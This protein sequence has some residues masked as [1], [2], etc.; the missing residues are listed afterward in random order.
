MTF[1]AGFNCSNGIVLCT[2]SLESDGI[3]KRSVNKIRM[4]GTAEWGIA[5]AGAGAPGIIEKF[6]DEVFARIGRGIYNRKKIEAV[7]EEVLSEFRSQYREDDDVFRVL[8]G[9][10]CAGALDYRLYRS[11]A[12]HLSPMKDHAHIGMGHSLWKFVSES[13]YAKGNSVEDN[14][15][16]G[17]FIMKLAIEHVGGVEGPIQ[18]VSYT[19]GDDAWRF[20]RPGTVWRL[21]ADFHLDKMRNALQDYWRRVNPPTH[22]E[23]LI[24]YGS[25]RLPG[26]E[27]TLLDGVKIEE[28]ETNAGR[29]RVSGFL[30]GNR[31]KLRKRGIL[32]RE[33]GQKP[34]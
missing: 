8:V 17:T 12:S 33:R 34:E 18:I 32:E 15:R 21:E 11:D 23:Q 22:S 25:V 4:S 26:D 1:V 24:K 28:L 10:H 20:L 2:D 27:V 7:V 6:C 13:L 29:N 31:D 19:S 3:T 16:L 5:I 30:F 14:T 9:L